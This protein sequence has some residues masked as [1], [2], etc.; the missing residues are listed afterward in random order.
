MENSLTI[1]GVA[2]LDVVYE[3]DGR[4]SSAGEGA[5]E[6]ARGSE[7]EIKDQRLKI[8]DQRSLSS[9][10]IVN[11]AHSVNGRTTRFRRIAQISENGKRIYIEKINPSKYRK[12]QRSSLTRYSQRRGQFE[13]AL[14]R[15]PYGAHW[16][17]L[18][19][20][21]RVREPLPSVMSRRRD[22]MIPDDDWLMRLYSLQWTTSAYTLRTFDR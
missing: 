7:E 3:G 9:C 21:E 20:L 19:E 11:S 5:Q 16:R 8:K 15:P 14:C 4:S 17:H 22:L 1:P 12:D 10:I 6:V 2:G 18:G 13:R